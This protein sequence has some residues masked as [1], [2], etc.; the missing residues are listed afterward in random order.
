[1]SLQLSELI[2]CHGNDKSIMET[3]D[4]IP[5]TIE[6]DYEATLCKIQSTHNVQQASDILQF[7]LS[8]QL[9]LHHD[10]ISI[11]IV[12]EFAGLAKPD[13][14][15]DIFPE[16]FLTVDNQSL[17]S[18]THPLVS[19]YLDSEKLAASKASAFYSL[20][21]ERS[22]KI[23]KRYLSYFFEQC[24]IYDETDPFQSWA[25]DDFIYHISAIKDDESRQTQFHD[26]IVEFFSRQRQDFHK[27]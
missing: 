1:M 8:Q 9:I 16:K 6:D 14:I 11:T 17:V 19:R 24:D 3:L 13:V 15:G 18:F 10:S 22:A 12:A 26:L 27:A 7:L 4:A 20:S 21:D 23:A 25:L 2:N 5:K